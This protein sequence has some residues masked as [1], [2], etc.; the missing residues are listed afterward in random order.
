MEKPLILVVEDEL[1]IALD[2]KEMLHEEGYDAVTNIVTV[3]DAI[4]AIEALNP[5]LVLVDINLNQ[6]KDGIDLGRYLLD[7]DTIPFIYLT[8]Y[9]DKATLERVSETRP[10]GYIVKPFKPEDLKTTVAI[11]LNN[12]K[13]RFVDAQRQEGEIISDISFILKQSI[14]YINENIREKITVSDLTKA[15]KWE[16]QHFTRLFTEYL[17]VTP[18]K[19]ILDR[20]IEKAKVLLTETALP[21]TQISFELSIKSHSNFC[22]MFKKATGKTP[23][24]YRKWQQA[25][26]K[27]LK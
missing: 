26:N 11:V 13:H 9:S 6:E 22:A 1:V 14:K 21:I 7:R 10:H 3:E 12:F 20:K 2:I 27:Y 25:Q 19:Y 23:E 8:S 18:S 16:S 5:S 4:K 24:E 15:T 17:G